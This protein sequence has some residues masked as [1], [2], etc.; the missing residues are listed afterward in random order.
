MRRSSACR[1]R[2]CRSRWRSRIVKYFSIHPATARAVARFRSKRS[3]SHDAR[4]GGSVRRPSTSRGTA[5]GS[6]AQSCCQSSSLDAVAWPTWSTSTRWSKTTSRSFTQT[7]KQRSTS[8]PLAISYSSSHRPSRARRRVASRRRRRRAARRTARAP[9]SRSP[10][11][12]RTVTGFVRGRERGH[13]DARVR[14]RRAPSRAVAPPSRAG[15]SM[16][17]LQNATNSPRAAARPW[18]IPRANPRFSALRIARSAAARG[19]VGRLALAS[20][21]RR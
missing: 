1:D 13:D 18:F 10:G 11:S 16:S 17:L 21:C 4:R 5:A 7:L 15:A 14:V 19:V 8:S 20:R 3:A 6:S 2:A 12:A 9:R